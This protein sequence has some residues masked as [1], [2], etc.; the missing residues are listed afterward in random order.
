MLILQN[1]LSFLVTLEDIPD[2]F[3]QHPVSS[4]H[5]KGVI[6]KLHRQDIATIIAGSSCAIAGSEISYKDP[7][8]VW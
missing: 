2:F 3:V 4:I 8:L 5:T 7:S 1:C 6:Q